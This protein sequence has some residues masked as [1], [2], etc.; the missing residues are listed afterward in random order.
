MRLRSDFCTRE[1]TATRQHRSSFWSRTLVEI[2]PSLLQNPALFA[3]TRPLSEADA[4]APDGGQLGLAVDAESPPAPPPAPPPRGPARARPRGRDRTAAARARAPA[5]SRTWWTGSALSSANA[6]SRPNWSSA[7]RP[8]NSPMRAASE[9]TA[10]RSRQRGQSPGTRNDH[11]RACAC[12]R[13]ERRRRASP[14][15]RGPT[16]RRRRSAR[17][18]RSSRSGPL[19]SACI[20]GRRSI[21]RPSPKRSARSSSPPPLR[22]AVRRPR[23]GRSRRCGRRRPAPARAGGRRRRARG[24]AAR[25]ASRR[26]ARVR[27]TRASNTD[28]GR[29]GAVGGGERGVGVGE[30]R[31]GR[32]VEPSGKQAIPAAA[33][34][35]AAA[36]AA[37][38]AHRRARA[39]RWPAPPGSRIANSHPPMRARRSVAAAARA[40]P[41]ATARQ[42]GSSAR[43]AASR[44]TAPGRSYRRASAACRSSA[45]G[46]RA[47]RGQASELVGDSGHA[48]STGP[49]AT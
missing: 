32:A 28:H 34:T 18:A 15:T 38:R 16:P 47:R 37:A 13:G 22:A 2:G 43:A 19:A 33:A 3:D 27:N 10:A 30:Q 40:A 41:R 26:P 23:G 21:S 8:P 1:A 48:L 25:R 39:P 36:R 45:I 11:A 29:V 12:V 7:S 31:A 5:S 20:D 24:A 4:E 17:R 44:I 6:P 14:R 46:E 35:P 9:R 49:R 42:P